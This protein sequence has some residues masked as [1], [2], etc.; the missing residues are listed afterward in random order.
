[1]SE[2]SNKTIEMPEEEQ[3]IYELGYLLA[4]IVS[5][6]KVESENERIRDVLESFGR[7]ISNEAP[8]MK[9]LEY[10]MDKIITG[11]KYNFSSAYF[12]FF[13][14]ETEPQNIENIKKEIEKNDNIIRFIIIAR[15]KDSLLEKK[16]KT[17]HSSLSQKK[18]LGIGKQGSV[19]AG[20]RINEEALDKTI[21]NLV[22]N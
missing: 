21:D 18:T 14:F 7:I 17:A 3:K 16:K 20:E 22:V 2:E 8:I 5:D 19:S 1:M 9:D 12:G 6:E 11:K 13:I 15:T 10:E 4:P